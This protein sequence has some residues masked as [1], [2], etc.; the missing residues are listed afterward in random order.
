MVRS[1]A[2]VVRL[3]EESGTRDVMYRGSLFHW[4]RSELD[5]TRFSELSDEKEMCFSFGAVYIF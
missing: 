4:S 3:E 5:R 2:P 1:E